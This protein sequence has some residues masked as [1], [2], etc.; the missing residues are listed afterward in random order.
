MFHISDQYTLR[1]VVLASPV[2]HKAYLM[3][4]PDLLYCILKKQYDEQ[5]LPEAIAAIR[6]KGL[7]MENNA[8]KAIA[9]LDIRRRAQEIGG[10]ASEPASLDEIIELLHFHQEIHFFLED[11]SQNAPRPAWID[12]A[13]WPTFLPL[14]LSNSEKRR[15]L[16]ALC[17]LQTHAYIF[18]TRENREDSIDGCSQTSYNRWMYTTLHPTEAWRLFSEPCSLGNA[19]KWDVCGHI[20]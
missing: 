16:R 5:L 9:L 17:R 10:R 6:S 13:Q 11:Y 18:G 19:K 3:V 1:S 20:C 8:E 4:R 15:F 12:P 2:C 7:D 14:N